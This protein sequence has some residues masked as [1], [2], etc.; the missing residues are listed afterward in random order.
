MEFDYS[1]CKRDLNAIC[2]SLLKGM[3]TN[4][5]PSLCFGQL[6]QQQ[7]YQQSEVPQPSQVIGLPEGSLGTY[8]KSSCKNNDHAIVITVLFIASKP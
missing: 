1:Y 6:Q 3:M 8:T 7:T 4:R 5:K 2:L